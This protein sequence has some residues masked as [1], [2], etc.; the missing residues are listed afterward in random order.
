MKVVKDGIA[1][2]GQYRGKKFIEYTKLTNEERQELT[3]I[4]TEKLEKLKQA[5]KGAGTEKNPYFF[6]KDPPPLIVPKLTEKEV[7]FKVAQFEQKG[8][9][10]AGVVYKHNGNV[11]VFFEKYVETVKEFQCDRCSAAFETRQQL[12][13]HKMKCKGETV[14]QAVENAKL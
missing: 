10:I 9:E 8:A 1:R 12:S 5:N 11:Q 3:R 13:G 2:D 4:H 14:I 7:N 6:F